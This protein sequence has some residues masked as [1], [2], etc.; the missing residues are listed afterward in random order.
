MSRRRSYMTYAVMAL[1]GTRVNISAIRRDVNGIL[2]ILV[3]IPAEV[4]CPVGRVQILNGAR[5]MIDAL[6]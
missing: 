3:A 2:P 6:T 1:G 5:D 4:V